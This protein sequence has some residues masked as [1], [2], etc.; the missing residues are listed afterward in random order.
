MSMRFITPTSLNSIPNSIQ[1]D[2]TCCETIGA[3]VLAFLHFCEL[4]SR[5]RS[6]RLVSKCRIQQNLLSH[7]VWI[8]SVYQHPNAYKCLSFLMQSVKQHLFSLF[9]WILLESSLSMF[10][11]NC[12]IITSNFTLI[13]QKVCEKINPIGFALRWPCDPQA[14]WRSVKVV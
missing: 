8:K 7:Q 11:L 4:E 12:F 3:Q 5:S 9:K 13:R 14:W 10:S 1:I 2:W 6:I